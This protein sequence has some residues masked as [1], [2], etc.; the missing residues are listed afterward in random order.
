MA[1]KS[2]KKKQTPESETYE[3]EI[4]DWEVAYI[5][6]L[7]TLPQDLVEGLFYERSRLI[8]SG[9]I[10]SPVV[11]NVSKVRIEIVN[12]PRLDDH[13]KPEPTIR[14]PKGI[15]WMEI[16]KGENT[17]KFSCY[18]PSRSLQNILLAV[19]SEKIRF[20]SIFGTKLKWRKGTVLSV[21]LSKDRDG[22]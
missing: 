9:N 2:K 6:E 8:L 15:G 16:P 4:N 7:N 13:W 19:E 14:S 1:K 10:L 22:A 3:I 17:L 5:F 20:V 18:I 11:K 21:K 12:E